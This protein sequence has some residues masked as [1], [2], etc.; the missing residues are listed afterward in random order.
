MGSGAH[1]L[2]KEKLVKSIW[3]TERYDLLH[4]GTFP[5]LSPVI[6]FKKPEAVR[7]MWFFSSVTGAGIKVNS[8]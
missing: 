8:V 1:T 2:K 3:G 7:A 5:F 4:Q 6:E